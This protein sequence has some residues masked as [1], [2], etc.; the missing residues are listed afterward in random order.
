MMSFKYELLKRIVIS[1]DWKK[2]VDLVFDNL[3]MPS[4]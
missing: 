2:A 1:R 4:G 3:K